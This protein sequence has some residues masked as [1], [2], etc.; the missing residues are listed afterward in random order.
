[1]H[2]GM[3]APLPP[4]RGG[5]AHY[6]TQLADAL[7]DPY[8]LSFRHLYPRWLYPG[9]SQ[10]D[11]THQPPH[12]P[13]DWRLD[14]TDPRTWTDAFHAL[15][16]AN[17]DAALLHWWTPYLAPCLGWLALRLRQAGIPTI[18]LIHNIL[19]HERFPLDAALTRWALS[20]AASC[21]VQTPA[22][23]KALTALLPV[24][25]VVRQPHPVDEPPAHARQPKNEARLRL[26]LPMDQT[27]LLM[28][29]VFRPYKGLDLLA[30][31]LAV[32]QQQNRPA[33]LVLLAGE[34]WRGAQPARQ[35]LEALGVRVVDRY[36]PEAG[37]GLYTSA[38]DGALAL[39]SGALSPSGALKRAM[40]WRLPVLVNVSQLCPED[41]DYPGLLTFADGDMYELADRLQQWAAEPPSPVAGWQPKFTWQSFADGLSLLF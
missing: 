26:G 31:A 29:G 33:P 39:A 30:D 25:P 4:Y 38:A 14:S 28:Q 7:S 32:L 18:Y 27:I 37:V 1:M 34:F 36:I 40:G 21:I 17:V 35:K 6:A 9:R 8:L 19:P 24:M 10:T 16:A 20:P 15:Q 23:E 11:P 13:V 12:Y 22:A 3:I 5:I 41:A 2:W